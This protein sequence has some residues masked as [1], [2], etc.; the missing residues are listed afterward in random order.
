MKKGSTTAYQALLPI[1]IQKRWMFWNLPYPYGIANIRRVDMIDLDK[2]GVEVQSGDR[3][4]EKARVG[5]R[6]NQAGPYTKDTKINLLLAFSGDDAT[7]CRWSE[8]WA[9]EG[10]TGVRM[11]NFIQNIITDL[12]PGNVMRRYCFIMDNLSAHHNIQ[13]AAIICAAGHRLAFRA[14]YY[15]VDSPIEYVFNTIQGIYCIN[16]DHIVEE[17]SLIHELLGSIASIPSFEPYFIN[18]RFLHN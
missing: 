16:M 4:W 12:G 6:V 15:P 7:R 11:I 9:G 1:N 8:H 10:T 13:M 18:C 17:S 5:K 3:S 2:C 14:P